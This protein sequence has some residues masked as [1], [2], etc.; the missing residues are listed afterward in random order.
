[1]IVKNSLEDERNEVTGRFRP[2][3]APTAKYEKAALFY[4][5]RILFT[6]K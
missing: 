4:Q 6:T 1:M 2:L 3:E 5:K